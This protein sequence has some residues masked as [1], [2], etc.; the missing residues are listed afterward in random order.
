MSTGWASPTRQHGERTQG[1]LCGIRRWI[2]PKMASALFFF[3]RWFQ[4]SFASVWHEIICAP[5]DGRVSYKLT[6]LR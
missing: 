6:C 5:L 2:R 1:R 4:P 3:G